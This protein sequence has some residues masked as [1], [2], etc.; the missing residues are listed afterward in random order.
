[1]QGLQTPWGTKVSKDFQLLPDRASS[2]AGQMDALFLFLVI[3]TAFFTLLI[4]GLI[5][6][7]AVRYRRREAHEVGADLPTVRWL[8]ITWT[9]APLAI[10]MI[11][12]IWGA[13]LFV[14][15][16]APPLN[17]TEIDV[18]GKQWMWKIQHANGRREINEL[19]VPL[20]RAIRLVMTSQD[21]VHSFYIPAFRV[22]QDVLPGRYSYEW[23]TP[24]QT[25]EYH[26]LC[27]QYCGTQH[28]RMVGRVVVMEPG[29]FDHWLEGE[30]QTNT[31]EAAGAALF[32]LYSCSQC[33]GQLAPT[34]A[35]LYMTTVKLDDGQ[36]AQAN[37][38]YLR[39]SI[40][41][42]QAKLVAG[43]GHIMPSYRGQLSE[44]QIM[45]LLAYIKSLREATKEAAP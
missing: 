2:I 22:K 43:Y 17:A 28:S 39:E 16:S 8:E 37:D 36:T 19:H 26:L 45:D 40:L 25:G 18:V 14:R 1:M 34:L 3:V 32:Q 41:D 24:T 30:P 4:A 21:V 5:V 7:F 29:D 42:S 44:E 10:A 27:S 9:I 13:E 20:G 31:R 38:D 35:G 12:F 11:M 15:L 6:T 23:F 33:H